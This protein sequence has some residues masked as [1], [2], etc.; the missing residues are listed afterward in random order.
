MAIYESVLILKPTLSDTEVNELLE[1]TKKIISSDGG[2]VL[3]E[4]RWGRRKLSTPIKANRE[5]NYIQLKFNGSPSVLNKLDHHCRVTDA[6]MRNMTVR[7]E[8][9]K[10]KKKKVKA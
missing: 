4:D 7:V 1:K 3:G 2:E 9:P 8:I 10:D 6:I 5:G